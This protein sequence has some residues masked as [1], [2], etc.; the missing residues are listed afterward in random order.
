MVP[1]VPELRQSILEEAYAT[2]LSIHL[3][4]NKMYQDL[5]QRFW[6]TKMK[7]EIARYIAKC[8]TCQKVKAIHLRSAGAC[9]NICIDVKGRWTVTGACG[10]YNLGGS[11]TVGHVKS[12]FGP[13][14]DSV[15][16]G[17][18]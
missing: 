3:G 8:D 4:S 5:K 6:W 17:A 2:R 10:P 11:A 16:V 9:G 15:S 18:R 12:C 1:K 13:F 7:I 14:G